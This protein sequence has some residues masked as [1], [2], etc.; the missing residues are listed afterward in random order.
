MRAHTHTHTLITP[1]TLSVE[2]L[3][4]T[5]CI[6]Q[7]GEKLQGH[8]FSFSLSHLGSKLLIIEAVELQNHYRC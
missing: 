3:T 6:S 8:T 4:M 5:A 1:K 7:E 2:V